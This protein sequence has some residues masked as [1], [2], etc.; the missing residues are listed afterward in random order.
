MNGQTKELSVETYV[1]G[2]LRRASGGR[3]ESTILATSVRRLPRL[4]P[5]QAQHGSLPRAVSAGGEGVVC[6]QAIE[7]GLCR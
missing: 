1:E 2:T 4:S 7:R 5:A 6:L 3:P